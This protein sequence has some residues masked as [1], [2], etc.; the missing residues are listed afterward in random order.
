MASIAVR[1]LPAG[2]HG[3][4]QHRRYVQRG[5]RRAGTAMASI[6]ATCNVGSGEL[7]GTGK[8]VEP[9]YVSANKQ[10]LATVPV[11]GKAAI[12]AIATL[13]NAGSGEPFRS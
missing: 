5:I 9:D 12:L 7:V 2:G 13:P 1:R 8:V 11:V 3:D 4:G 6:A 10:G